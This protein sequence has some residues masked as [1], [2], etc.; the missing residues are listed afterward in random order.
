MIAD[1]LSKIFLTALILCGACVVTG[2]LVINKAERTIDISSQLIKVSAAITYENKDA[3]AVSSIL[4]S[5]DPEWKGDLSYIAAKVSALKRIF[6]NN[7]VQISVV[8]FWKLGIYLP[9]VQ[10]DRG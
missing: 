5:S 8:K 1:H 4:F 6:F 10:H 3:S 7:V 9:E 2:S